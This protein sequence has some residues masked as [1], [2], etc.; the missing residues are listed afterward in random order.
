MKV[1]VISTT[2]LPCPPEGYSGLEQLAY[3]QAKGLAERGHQ[4]LLVAPIGSKPPPGV[5]LH[6]T[7][8][9]ESEKQAY[10]G[11][12]QKLPEFDAIIDNSVAG[13][14]QM[15][16]RIDGKSRWMT[17][18][19]LF[20]WAASRGP[21]YIHK[22][23]TSEIPVFGLETLSAVN[24]TTVR[25]RPVSTVIRHAR[26][27][28]LLSV[29]VKGS[30]GILLTPGHGLITADT[31]EKLGSL[32]ADASVGI[33]VACAARFPVSD[34]DMLSMP[35]EYISDA[36]RNLKGA[37]VRLTDDMLQFLG[38]WI[39]DGFYDK[40]SVKLA[41]GTETEGI[42]QRV[43]AMFGANVKP[44]FNRPDVTH[45]INCAALKRAMIA[46]GFEGHSDTKKV[47]DWV[48]DLSLRQIGLLLRGCFSADGHAS[49]IGAKHPKVCFNSVNKELVLQLQVLLTLVGIQSKVYLSHSR[50]GFSVGAG[51]PMWELSVP[52]DQI[53][54]FA[55]VIGFI[56]EE[57]TRRL[58]DA[59]SEDRSKRGDFPYSLIRERKVRSDSDGGD[60]RMVS[61][62]KIERLKGVAVAEALS[63]SDVVWRKVK[64]AVPVES[65]DEYVYDLS[66]PGSENFFVG[67]VCCHNSW[68]KWSYMLKIEGKLKAPVLGV[69]HAPANTM[70]AK[71]PPLPKPCIVAISKDQAAAASECWGVS[72]RVVYNGVDLD[73]Y[74]APFGSVRSDRYLFLAR[75]S[76]I[77]GPHIAVAL[78]EK[79]KFGLDLVG[80]DKI[81]GEP[82]YAQQLRT[83]CVGG[84]VYQ[85][86][87]NRDKCVEYFS[88]RKALLH[89]NQT[90]REPFGLAPVEANSC[91]MPVIAFDNG[92]MR[93]TIKQG[94][95]GFLVKSEAEV[96]QL[97]KDDAVSTIKPK[98]CREWASQFSYTAMIDGYIKA[99]EE[100]IDKPW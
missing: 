92:A 86:G 28:S 76:S 43:A 36:R 20:D 97:I 67:T 30:A 82:D 61:L 39:G 16:V 32:R 70:Y 48:F 79:L 49:K 29:K 22:N 65:S 6:G 8:M 71:A 21:A 68:E 44:N 18:S 52:S 78:A 7:T 55:E 59:A 9:R 74:K 84:I 13:S 90:Y 93:E 100:A 4:V 35:G 23:G 12:W 5:S 45:M 87:V 95:T 96:E 80:D 66:V 62:S 53:S 15:L 54:R 69:I 73:F 34:L 89:M 47:P 46:A 85:G 31:S 94:E 58:L 2:I 19:A 11:Y 50:G 64:S 25:W 56:Q 37:P 26:K 63:S 33:P 38:L 10:S 1:A 98:A 17:L 41:S 3:L 91:G 72:A 60:K 40:A 77:K 14:E 88:T 51:R 83:R 42:S 75:M 24:T 57:K 99:C 81:T 27:E